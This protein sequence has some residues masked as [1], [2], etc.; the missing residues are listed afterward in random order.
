M[1]NANVRVLVIVF[2]LIVLV[3]AAA[4]ITSA[5]QTDKTPNATGERVTITPA[6]PEKTKD[7][8]AYLRIQVGDEIWPPIPLTDG[9]E[10]TVSQHDNGAKNIIRTTKEGA[11]MHFSTCDNQNCVQQGEV[12][13][14]NLDFR[15]MGNLI[16][17]L[18]NQVVLE[19]LNAGEVQE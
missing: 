12:T 17:C 14:S 8:Q 5:V 13:L 19:L 6:I 2:A 9:G 15:A 3:A 7:T 18:P 10:Y 11:V 16:V 1:K 4:G